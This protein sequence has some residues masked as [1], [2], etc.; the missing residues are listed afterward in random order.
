MPD[1]WL[2]WC[3]PTVKAVAYAS[4]LGVLGVPG[5]R[6]VVVRAWPRHQAIDDVHERLDWIARVCAATLVVALLMRAWAHT[7]TAF[8]ASESLAWSNLRVVAFDSRWGGAWRAQM[9]AALAV[10]ACAV[11]ADLWHRRVWRW[12]T[13]L[14][15]FAAALALTGSGHAASHIW[16]RALHASHL[17]AA[18]AWAGVLAALTVSTRR[19]PTDERLRAFRS[20]APLATVAVATALTTGIVMA[21]RYLGS[22]DALTSAY[23]A[24]LATKTMLVLAM[25]ALGGF[26]WTR[27]RR[28]AGAAW[29]RTI[30]V[31]VAVALVVVLVTAVLTE[32]AHP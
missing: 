30:D 25:A 23:A 3:E 16:L 15:A 19:R 8:G 12:L 6:A 27:L 29:L 13:A 22:L 4:L 10:L 9:T 31:E 1:T 14:A 7:A 32:T 5:A 11:G 26:N 28:R 24:W 17:V 2:L 18:G 20:V 21:A